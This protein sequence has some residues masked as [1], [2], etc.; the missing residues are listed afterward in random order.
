M[1]LMTDNNRVNIKYLI[2][3]CNFRRERIYFRFPQSYCLLG[4]REQFSLELDNHGRDPGIV[5]RLKYSLG[6]G[7]SQNIYY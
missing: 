2:F 4:E 1:E 3:F 7:V 5:W 6:T